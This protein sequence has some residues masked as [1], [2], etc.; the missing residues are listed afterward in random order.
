MPS[1]ASDR[2]EIVLV[3]RGAGWDVSETSEGVLVE[4]DEVQLY[5]KFTEGRLMGAA[6]LPHTEG[7]LKA[8]VENFLTEQ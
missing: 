4:R 6:P 7:V 1:R 5:L 3:A 2:D 8:R